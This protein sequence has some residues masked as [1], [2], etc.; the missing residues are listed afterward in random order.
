VNYKTVQQMREEMLLH[1]GYSS[2]ENKVE[3]RSDIS[4]QE[5]WDLYDGKWY[6]VLAY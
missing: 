4:L 2:S 1:Y 5:F 6:I 3:K